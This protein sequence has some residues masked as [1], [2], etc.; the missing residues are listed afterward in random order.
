[1][2]AIIEESEVASAFDVGIERTLV[3]DGNGRARGKIVPL[4]GSPNARDGARTTFAGIDEGHRMASPRLLAAH[5]TMLANLP[6]RMG[7]DP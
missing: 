6:K 1:M 3:L 2:R 4:S 5:R 7:S